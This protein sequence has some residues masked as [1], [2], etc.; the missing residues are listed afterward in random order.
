MEL[1]LALIPLIGKLLA[2][3][4]GFAA[5]A[6]VTPNSS[7]NRAIHGI[8]TGINVFGMNLGKATNHP[9]K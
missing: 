7:K 2:A 8:L 1:F 4:G 9:A 5:V 3:I 6:T